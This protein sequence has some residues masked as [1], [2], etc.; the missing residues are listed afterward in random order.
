MQLLKSTK[1]KGVNL[2]SK[3]KIKDYLDQ[4]VYINKR[5]RVELKIG[6]MNST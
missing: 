3:I 5:G 6:T 4:I 2:Y 1:L